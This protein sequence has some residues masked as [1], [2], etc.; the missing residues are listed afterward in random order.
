MGCSPYLATRVIPQS[1][2]C[3]QVW[4]QRLFA[5]RAESLLFPSSRIQ[6]QQLSGGVLVPV[7]RTGRQPKLIP[8]AITSSHSAAG[9]PRQDR[10]LFRTNLTPGTPIEDVL[11]E[12]ARSDQDMDDQTRPSR[13]VISGGRGLACPCK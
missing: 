11:S 5:R 6:G 8:G 9:L 4:S 1:P 13:A 7:Q 10:L 2:F 3:G 12:R